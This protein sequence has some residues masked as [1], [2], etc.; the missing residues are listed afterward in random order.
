MLCDPLLSCS[1]Y[2]LNSHRESIPFIEKLCNTKCDIR[3]GHFAWEY[4][5]RHKNVET[6]YLQLDQYRAGLDNPPLLVVCDIDTFIIHTNF[7]NAPRIIYRFP[8]TD[9]DSNKPG[10]GSLLTPLQMLQAVFTEPE[11]LHPE[12]TAAEVA[13]EAASQL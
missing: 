6:A 2:Y 5:G 4:K 7:T 13:K 11:K 3:G 1:I 12:Y 10:A 9:L 8:L